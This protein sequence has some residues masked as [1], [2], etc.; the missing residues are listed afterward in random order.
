MTN[1]IISVVRSFFNLVIALISLR[2][3]LYHLEE[4][5]KY[6]KKY[7]GN[8][9]MLCF[10]LIITKSLQIGSG[11]MLIC[12]ITNI[13]DNF[14]VFYIF[15]PLL[16]VTNILFFRQSHTIGAMMTLVKGGYYIGLAFV[17]GIQYVSGSPDI[18]ELALGFTLALSIFEGIPNLL[19]GYIKL[20]YIREMNN[21]S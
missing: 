17:S 3:S 12:S 8:T 11:I 4:N 1:D 10:R 6:A 9:F 14:I 15:T 19:D 13:I 2:L 16:V 18:A 20:E 21:K 7:A 5:K